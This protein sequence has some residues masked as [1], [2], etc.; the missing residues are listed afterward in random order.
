MSEN[1]D[2]ESGGIIVDGDIITE[3]CAN[4]KMIIIQ[5]S[6]PSTTKHGQVWNDSS[7]NPILFKYRDETNSL[8]ITRYPIHYDGSEKWGNP[9]L[10]PATNG[11]IITYIKTATVEVRLCIKANG[12]WWWVGD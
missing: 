8:W 12:S 6:P 11:T 7:H 9:T 4:T 2:H 1:T 5:D 10:S 3:P